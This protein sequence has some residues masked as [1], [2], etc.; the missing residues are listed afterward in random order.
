MNTEIKTVN[1]FEKAGFN[2]EQ[3]KSMVVGIDD[4]LVKSMA[5]FREYFDHRFDAFD[6]R[7]EARFE[8]IDHR[9]DAF[10]QRFEA[11][12]E[13]IDHRFGAIDHRIH[14]LEGSLRSLQNFQTISLIS[15]IAA[16]LVGFAGL[17]FAVLSQS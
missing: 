17:I 3:S 12:F 1:R 10:D 5:A 13:A 14:T 15:I 7:F 4:L 6:Q 16:M 8:A 11:R 2:G 9:F